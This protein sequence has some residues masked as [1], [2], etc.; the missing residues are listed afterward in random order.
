MDN[1]VVVLGGGIGGMTAALELVERGFNVY[2]FELKKIPGGK[3]RTIPVPNSGTGGRPD[4]PGEHGF[5]F[6]PSFYVHLPDT[7]KRIPFGNTGRTCFDNLVPTTRIDLAQYDLPGILALS[8]FP[9]NLR[10]LEV[11]IADLFANIDLRPGEAEFFAARMWQVMTSCDERRL[12]QLELLS[13][14]DYVGAATRS[15]AYQKF[16][17]QGLSRSLVAA[18]AEDGS[19]RTIGQIQVRLAFGAIDPEEPSTDRVLNGPTSPALLQPWLKYLTSQRVKYLRPFN[20]TSIQTS[21]GRIVSVTVLNLDDH[22][23]STV[24]ADWFISALPVEVMGPLITDDMVRLDPAL[25]NVKALATNVRWMNGIQFYLT[26]D[27]PVI[28]GHVLYVDSPWAI[29]SISQPQFWP[30][31]PMPNYGDGKV[32]G[33]I[34]VDISD[35][36]KPGTFIKQAAKDCETRDEIAKEVWQELKKSLNVGGNVLLRDDMLLSYFLDTDIIIFDPMRPRKDIN[37]EP[38]FI[39]RPNSW[40]M[41]PP[42]AS[43]ISNFFLAADYVQT[44]SDLACME[45]ANE[46]A[47]RAVNALL[48][49][50][51]SP[52]SRCRIWDMGMPEIFAPWRWNDRLRYW[53]GKPWNGE[54]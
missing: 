16:L 34:S 44:N 5:R 22:T 46:A 37:L 49:R 11:I 13:W 54:L 14:W 47:R 39:N 41:R 35:W 38:L 29:T 8:G 17:A 15:P 53:E 32:K 52:A 7:M 31:Y 28:N 12:N 4:L 50:A 30:D 6:F 43:A 27:V 24:K 19:A 2:V 10:D 3:S 48:D 26:E 51:G 25:G 40:A 18:R 21:G 33:V 42:A 36:D 45:A 23:E 9:K 20:V 1:T